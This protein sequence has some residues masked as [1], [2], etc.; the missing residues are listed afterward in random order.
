MESRPK[1]AKELTHV[2][3]GHGESPIPPPGWG[4]VETIIW[5]LYQNLEARS[6]AVKIVNKT[7]YKAALDVLRLSL[8]GQADVVY[9]HTEKPMR[10]MAV[11]ARWRKFILISTIHAP[12]LS[13]ELS[14]REIRALHRCSFAPFHLTLRDDIQK[15]VIERNPSAKCLTL[16]NGLE[17]MRFQTQVNGN[18]KA[19][20]L[21]RIQARKRQN[22][23]AL[24]LK[25]SG[26]E[27]DFVGP[28]IKKDLP[29]SDDLRARLAGE[30]DRETV[31]KRLCEY[32]CLILL[33]QSEGQP[34]AVIEALAAGIPVVVYTQAAAKLENHKPVIF[35]AERDDQVVDLVRQAILVRDDFTSEIRKY[36]VETFD[37]EILVDKYLAQ[38]EEWITSEKVH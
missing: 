16:K 3:V 14:S 21:G 29:I 11:L 10:L 32:S 33:S 26:I 34:L 20:V 6:I 2:L 36:A 9:S 13:E 35:V 30:W 37:Y 23:T 17:T 31:G 4:A 12:L 28:V 19:I 1:A 7:R 15:L 38:V 25:G 22:E 18:G 24:I 27:C 8:R 5:Q